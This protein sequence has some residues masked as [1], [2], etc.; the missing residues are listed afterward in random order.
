MEQEAVCVYDVGGKFIGYAIRKVG[1]MQLASINVYRQSE[2]KELNH[3]IRRANEEGT[4][5]AHWPSTSDPEVEAEL[6]KLP[7]EYEDQDVIDERNSRI[8]TAWDSIQQ[9]DVINYG[10]S[11]IAYKSMK[12]PVPSGAIQR[13]DKACETVA[14]RRAGLDA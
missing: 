2:V 11:D 4:V 9:M 3:T 8:V 10:E 7:V 14:R 13:L 5:R 1:V 12:L 6:E